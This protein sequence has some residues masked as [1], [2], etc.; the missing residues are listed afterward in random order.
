MKL[1]V[2]GKVAHSQ[3]ISRTTGYPPVLNQYGSTNAYTNN[4]KHNIYHLYAKNLKNTMRRGRDI[5]YTNLA[6]PL[7]QE[8]KFNFLITRVLISVQNSLMTWNIK[9]KNV[10]N[11]DPTKIFLH[12]HV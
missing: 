11:I 9:K 2:L 6:L 3:L 4:S 5:Q 8:I 10:L 1:S 7:I 12:L